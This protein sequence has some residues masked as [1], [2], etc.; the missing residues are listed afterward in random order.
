MTRGKGNGLFTFQIRMMSNTFMCVTPVRSL[1]PLRRLGY[2]ASAFFAAVLGHPFFRAAVD[3]C[4]TVTL[5]TP[6]INM[7]TGPR[8]VGQV[9]ESLSPVAGDSWALLPIRTFYVNEDSRYDALRF[10]THMYAKEW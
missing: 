3:M 4:R 5:N 10:G 9:L 7:Y 2:C 1:E 8:L 6:N